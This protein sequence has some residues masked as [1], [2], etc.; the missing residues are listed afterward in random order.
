MPG[1]TAEYEEIQHDAIQHRGEQAP[2]EHAHAPGGELHE[3]ET[4]A[5]LV[6][7]PMLLGRFIDAHERHRRQRIAG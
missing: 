7:G 1:T 3:H 5:L 6:T 2:T 4:A